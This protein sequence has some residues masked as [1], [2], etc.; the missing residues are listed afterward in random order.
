MSNF[1]SGDLSA[2]IQIGEGENNIQCQSVE[3]PV[4]LMESKKIE[5]FGCRCFPPVVDRVGDDAEA[6]SSLVFSQ[7]IRTLSYIHRLKSS[8]PSLTRALPSWWDTICDNLH[9]I[10]AC[11][12][13]PNLFGPP[14]LLSSLG[15]Y[16]F[17]PL[18][19]SR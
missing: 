7:K 11:A 18:F 12:H 8:G 3:V 2:L 10:N 13:A 9:V 16:S 14:I 4:W 6:Q 1:G 17:P 19:M 5:I 15:F